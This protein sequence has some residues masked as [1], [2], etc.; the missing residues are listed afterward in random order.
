MRNLQSNTELGDTLKRLADSLGTADSQ[1]TEQ[2]SIGASYIGK[3][4]TLDDS[5]VGVVDRALS[6]GGEILVGVNGVDVP[7]SRVVT[8]QSLIKISA[9]TPKITNFSISLSRSIRADGTRSMIVSL[10]TAS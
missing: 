2:L 6:E 10:N 5:S 7:L 9:P 3:S 4:V 1:R 8:V